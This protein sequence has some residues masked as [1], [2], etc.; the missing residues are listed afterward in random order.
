MKYLFFIFML[1][2]FFACSKDEVKFELT[3]PEVFAYDLGDEWEVNASVVV[4][5]F[6]VK[7]SEQKFISK[8][9]F[10][11]DL[12]TPEGVTLKSLANGV[13]DSSFDEKKNDLSIDA[14][15]SLDSSYVLGNYKLIIN[16]K[17]ELSQKSLQIEKDFELT[18]ED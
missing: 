3:N 8:L 5:G 9:A 17:D 12:T 2:A 7:E 4:K 18:D 13:K 10:N 6:Q 11:L 15:F 1:F 14:Q 16:I